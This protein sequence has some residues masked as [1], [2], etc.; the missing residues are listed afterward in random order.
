M[1]SLGARPMQARCRKCDPPWHENV[2]SK[3][4]APASLH[5]M[6]PALQVGPHLPPPSMLF[7]F[8]LGCLVLSCFCFG[9]NYKPFTLHIGAT[10]L[11][12]VSCR[13]HRID[14]RLADLIALQQKHLHN[15]S[16]WEPICSNYCSLKLISASQW[17]LAVSMSDLKDTVCW[18]IEHSDQDMGCQCSDTLCLHLPCLYVLHTIPMALLSLMCHHAKAT[19]PKPAFHWS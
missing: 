13:C 15:V 1:H 7:L 17:Y 11:S 19:M 5:L 3:W 14:A 12:S 18:L 9:L 8:F 4:P 16:P 6:D 2:C 10:G